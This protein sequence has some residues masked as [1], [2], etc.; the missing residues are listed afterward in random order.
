VLA[1]TE[2]RRLSDQLIRSWATFARTGDPVDYAAE[3]KLAFWSRL[4][5]RS[6]VARRQR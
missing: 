5:W 2:Q 3:H 1:T 6:G 4:P